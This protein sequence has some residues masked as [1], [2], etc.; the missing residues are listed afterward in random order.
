MRMI[1]HAKST[2][3]KAIVQIAAIKPV[4]L[5]TVGTVS[6]PRFDSHHLFRIPDGTTFS[7]SSW[8]PTKHH[9]PK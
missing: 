2:E 7:S 6:A 8:E 9:T 3:N 5:I 1:P 4:G